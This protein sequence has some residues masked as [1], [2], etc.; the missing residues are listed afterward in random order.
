[1]AAQYETI[2]TPSYSDLR[3]LYLGAAAMRDPNA[4]P[5]QV[6]VLANDSTLSV[7]GTL[8]PEGTIRGLSKLYGALHLK[9]GDT[10]KFS[11]VDDGNV[12][13]HAPIVNP[14]PPTTQPVSVFRRMGLNHMHITPF[15][16]VNL[17]NWE[18]QTE[19]DIYLA[20]GVLHEY[21]DFQYCCGVSKACLEA[22]GANYKNTAKPDAILI[23]RQ[24]DSYVMS[25][26]K[27]YSSDYKKNHGPN[28]VDVLVCWIHDE[29]DPTFLP[30]RVLA[31]HSVAMKAAQAKW[32][33]M[34]CSSV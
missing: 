20:F 21:T 30:P 1:M 32:M 4:R 23:D 24:T 15:E 2:I 26:W 5:G 18:P 12:V 34:A 10:I 29:T 28:D 8:I 11:F 16:A 25:E 31:L 17:R 33:G 3:C 13:V 14:Q 19:T 9:Q 6:T 27:M 7:D 22:L